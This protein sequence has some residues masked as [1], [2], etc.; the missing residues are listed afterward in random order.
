MLRTRARLSRVCLPMATAVLL[1][2][3][4]SSPCVAT[5]IT[6]DG[7]S[8]RPTFFEGV[9]VDWGDGGGI[10]YYDVTV[11]WGGT[12]AAIFGYGDYSLDPRLVAWGDLPKADLAVGALADALLSDGFGSTSLT[13]YL[14]TALSYNSST[15][16][17]T[18][19]QVNLLNGAG[20]SIAYWNGGRSA[21]YSSS[22]YSQW[23]LSPIPE[24]TTALLL[25]CG[26]AG[27]S[28]K[29]RRT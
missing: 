13:S 4:A 27:L 12:F 15:T 21:S 28:L 11:T 8:S 19:R 29:R 2:A 17:I 7:A 23:E 18:G 25:A 10:Q 24:P 16:V 5:T 6:Y 3:L 14:M 20:S 22:G 26:L 9:G 1:L